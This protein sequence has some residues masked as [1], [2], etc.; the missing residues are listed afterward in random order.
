VCRRLCATS[1]KHFK[2]TLFTHRPRLWLSS[3]KIRGRWVKVHPLDD[4][5]RPATLGIGHNSAHKLARGDLPVLVVRHRRREQHRN[6]VVKFCLLVSHESLDSLGLRI[7]IFMVCRSEFQYLGLIHSACTTVR[8]VPGRSSGLLRFMHLAVRAMPGASLVLTDV[9]PRRPQ[10]KRHCRTSRRDVRQSD[11]IVGRR[12]ATSANQ[13]CS[14]GGSSSNI[15]CCYY[16]GL[17]VYEKM[18]KFQES[19]FP[20]GLRE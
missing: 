18:C 13:R 6:I 2:K 3:Y 12:G 19:F 16:V 14:R 15:I 8:L 11:A 20:L 4:L 10:I 1:V 17:R 7:W 5:S 9:A